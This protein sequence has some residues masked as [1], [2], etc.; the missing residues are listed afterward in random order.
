MFTPVTNG[1]TQRNRVDKV[2]NARLDRS[3]L[4]ARRPAVRYSYRTPPGSDL[5][6][7]RR[8][9]NDES[10]LVDDD[11]NLLSSQHFGL[12]LSVHE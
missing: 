7:D 5:I 10:A 8:R 3:K 9:W 12:S 4:N 11:K 1:N 6:P 2:S